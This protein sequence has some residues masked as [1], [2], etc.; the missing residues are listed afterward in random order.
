MT[1][2]KKKNIQPES[3]GQRRRLGVI[4]MRTA[5]IRPRHDSNAA[6]FFSKIIGRYCT[7]LR[8]NILYTRTLATPFAA[9]LRCYTPL[10]SLAI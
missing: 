9:R 1:L 10:P 7:R 6:E 3:T 8:N 4:N 2:E 5:I